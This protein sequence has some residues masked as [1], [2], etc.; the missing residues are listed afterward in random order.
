MES[1]RRFQ[2][3]AQVLFNACVELINTLLTDWERRRLAITR[4]HSIHRSNLA[5]WSRWM[6]TNTQTKSIL[7]GR[8]SSRSFTVE[9]TKWPSFNQK[10]ASQLISAKLPRKLSKLDE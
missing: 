2:I 9:L 5:E 6:P 3:A 1:Y 8:E 4:V 7:K 10:A